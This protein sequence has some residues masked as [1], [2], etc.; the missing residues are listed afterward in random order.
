[1]TDSCTDGE[2]KL[3]VA[4]RF[5]VESPYPITVI[6]INNN[7]GATRGPTDEGKILVNLEGHGV[8]SFMAI[9]SSIVEQSPILKV[10]IQLKHLIL[11][12]S[13]IVC[14]TILEECY[15]L[16]SNV[17]PISIEIENIQSVLSIVST[18]SCGFLWTILMCP[19]AT[20]LIIFKHAMMIIKNESAMW[21]FSC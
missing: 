8:A 10:V 14:T 3:F 5:P 6:P 17:T 1:M 16:L 15:I 4:H 9:L 2:M 13:Y 21:I 18:M 19:H 12:S 7:P 20:V 11:K